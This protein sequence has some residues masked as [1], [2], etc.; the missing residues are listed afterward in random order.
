MVVKLKS[1]CADFLLARRLHLN[2]PG[3]FDLYESDFGG[4]LLLPKAGLPGVA[5]RETKHS[6]P[7]EPV[8]DSSG[9]SWSGQHPCWRRSILGSYPC[10]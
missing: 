2:S 7:L 5:T 1:P 10:T 6:S 3:L 9:C 8:L 4:S